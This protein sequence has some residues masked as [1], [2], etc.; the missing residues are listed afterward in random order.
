MFKTMWI[1]NFA[2]HVDTTI[3]LSDLTLI[4]GANNSGKSNL[5][6]AINHFSKLISRA[7]PGN[8]KDKKIKNSDFFPY[9]HSLS[10]AEA[11]MEFQCLWEKHGYAIEYHLIL[12]PYIKADEKAISCKEK[13]NITDTRSNQTNRYEHG[14]N[15]TSSEMLLRTNINQQNLDKDT[16]DII[17]IFFK[18]LSFAYYYN[19]QPSFLK[20]IGVPFKYNPRTQQYAPHAHTDFCR[21]YETEHQN[22]NIAI[23]MGEQGYNFQELVKYVK[24][25]EDKTYGRFR[26]Y[27]QRFVKSFNAIIIEKDRV[28]WQFDMGNNN[29]SYYD[30]EKISEGML[31]AGAVA[32]LCAMSPPPAIVMLE[33]VENGINQKNLS[34][35][36]GWLEGASDE[37]GTQFILTS[38]SPSVIREFNQDLDK[39]YKIDLKEKSGYKSNL[40]NLNDAISLL[41]SINTIDEDAIIGYKEVDGNKVL[42]IRAYELTE[43][44]YNGVLGNL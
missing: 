38:H 11:P 28:K 15:V 3:N 40:T 16:L 30:A 33:G 21:R 41:A 27:L 43:L 34:E 37:N 13:L 2:T 31:K 36:L 44:F 22:V 19:L 14:D 24:K 9:R 5:L 35:F 26:A 42:Q 29:F 18:S 23:G 7:F 32:L 17:E 25:H 8:D 10:D 39:V 20:G 6:S 12:S 1:K 4:I